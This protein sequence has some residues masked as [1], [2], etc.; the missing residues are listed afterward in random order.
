MRQLVND[1]ETELP[2]MG[3]ANTITL[4]IEFLNHIMGALLHREQWQCESVWFRLYVRCLRFM[5]ETQCECF[6]TLWEMLAANERLGQFFTPDEV[7][8][9]MAHIILA[10]ADWDSFTMTH[11]LVIGEPT[12][13]GGKTLLGVLRQVPDGCLHKVQ[14]HATELDRNV[15]ICCAL[16]MLHFNANSYVIQGDAI[17]LKPAIV[18]HTIHDAWKGGEIEAIE[19][20]ARMQFIMTM[21][22]SGNLQKG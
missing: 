16:N 4:Y 13:G 21:A 1:F 22:L 3:D 6:A 9:T 17:A 5:R 8:S 7:C 10:N 19:D 18:Y 11:P 20:E 2:K 14:F 12:A 15:A